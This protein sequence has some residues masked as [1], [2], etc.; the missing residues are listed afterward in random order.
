M[1]LVVLGSASGMPVAHR[2]SSS[3]WLQREGG[4]ILLDCGDGCAR[5]IL[6]ASCDPLEIDAVAITH[7]HSDHWTGIGLLVQMY[8]QLKRKKPLAVA[9]PAAGIK[10]IKAALEASYMWEE[11]IGFPIEWV[12]WRAGERTDIAGFSITPH[13]NTHLSG[14]LSGLAMH[15]LASLESYSL[16]V[17]ADGKRGIYS[18]DIGSLSDLEK[19][20][21]EPADWL[22]VEGMH[23]PL[24]DFGPWLSSKEVGRV[25]VTHIPPERE[26][27]EFP[28]GVVVARDGLVVEL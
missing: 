14:Y 8:H 23:F 12:T 5:N 11:R 15:P 16:V 22:L 26:G 24:E 19:L 27:A 7:M 3:Y 6:A 20:L 9:A 18:G 13:P 21:K 2:G 17:E 28:E 1:K 4:V 25:I 10:V